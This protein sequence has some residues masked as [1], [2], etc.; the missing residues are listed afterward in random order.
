L[1][2]RTGRVGSEVGAI[3]GKCGDVWHIVVAL[4]KDRIVQ[5]QCGE[6]GAR[7]RYRPSGGASAG[8]ARRRRSIARKRPSSS[9]KNDAKPI[10]EADTS[11]PSRSFNPKDTY[12][13][14]DRLVHPTFG[15]GVVQTTLGPTKVEVLFEAGT[16]LL[17]Q[18]QGRS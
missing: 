15:E 2:G 5:I 17:V 7:H 14:G 11:R 9:R 8:G 3:C 6:C 1:I 4:K 10:V 12:Q 13:V 18:R 16:K